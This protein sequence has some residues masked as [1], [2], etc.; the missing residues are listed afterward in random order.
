MT[1]NTKLH[2]RAFLS[3]SPSTPALSQGIVLS[4]QS[5]DEKLELKTSQDSG[6]TLAEQ[7]RKRGVRQLFRW[8]FSTKNHAF[9]FRLYSVA[10]SSRFL[11]VFFTFCSSFL[12]LVLS[13]HRSF[14]DCSGLTTTLDALQSLTKTLLL[15][16]DLAANNNILAVEH[17]PHPSV[18]FSRSTLNRD[19]CAED[20][21]IPIRCHIHR[22]GAISPQQ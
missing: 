10:C 9:D 18:R 13:F 16:I 7:R 12:L 6:P 2:P 15:F 5:C 22:D 3:S 4:P 19:Q 8:S 1:S 11:A 17:T 20:E 21:P 14:L